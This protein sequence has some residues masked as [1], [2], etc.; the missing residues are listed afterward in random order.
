MISNLNNRKMIPHISQ[1]G[2]HMNLMR[3]KR[4]ST[5]HDRQIL[6]TSSTYVIAFSYEGALA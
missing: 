5:L 3:G 1:H 4:I 6:S 2:D